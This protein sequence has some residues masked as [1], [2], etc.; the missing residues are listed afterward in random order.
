MPFS[1]SSI[2]VG[3]AAFVTVFVSGG[4]ASSHSFRSSTDGTAIASQIRDAPLPRGERLVRAVRGRFLPG[5]GKQVVVWSRLP[6]GTSA[7]RTYERAAGRW[8]CLAEG[9]HPNIYDLQVGDVDRD[10]YD[11][12]VLGLI[13]RSKLDVTEQRRLFIYGVDPAR[14]FKPKWRGSGL[15]RPFHSFHLLPEDGGVDIVA[16]EKNTLPEYKDFD[17]IGVYRWNGFGLRRVWETPVRGRVEDLTA[18]VD[19]T[20]AYVMFTQV[21]GSPLPNPSPKGRGLGFGVQPRR[22]GSSLQPIPSGGERR[23]SAWGGTSRQLIMR[24]RHTAKGGIEFVTSV[25]R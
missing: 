18:G 9:H 2:L 24:P 1:R 16:L 22:H 3:V 23:G 10:G 7:L 11:D 19:A 25:V 20:G 15:S 12:V 13:Q 6:N 8:R 5:E 17:W 4:A 21:S 14:G